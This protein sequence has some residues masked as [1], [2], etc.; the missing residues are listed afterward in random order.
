ML[1][2]SGSRGG[3]RT[4]DAMTEAIRRNTCFFESCNRQVKEN[5][6]A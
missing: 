4:D 6:A 5:D 2:I 3:G 1:T